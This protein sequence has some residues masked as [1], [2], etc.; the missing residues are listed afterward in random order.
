MNHWKILR[1]LGF[2][3]FH[4]TRHEP[5]AGDAVPP[6]EHGSCGGHTTGGLAGIGGPQKRLSNDL[7]FFFSPKTT[8]EACAW[9]NLP[10]LVGT[11]CQFSSVMAHLEIVP[12]SVVVG[13]SSGSRNL[14]NITSLFP[15]GGRRKPLWTG[16][17]VTDT[18]H[19]QIR[20]LPIMLFTCMGPGIIAGP[21]RASVSSSDTEDHE[22]MRCFR[23]VPVT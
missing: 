9:G 8:K 16:T 13:K 10:G 2:F 7:L 20:L 19:A 18:M 1:Q 23:L 4:Q 11:Y 21:L 22:V 12:Q 3:L 6:A 17:A 14:S 15:G 5:Q